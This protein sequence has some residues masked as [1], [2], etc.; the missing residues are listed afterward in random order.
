MIRLLATAWVLSGALGV[1][2]LRSRRATTIALGVVLGPISLVW[3]MLSRRAMTAERAAARVVP[4]TRERSAVA[5]HA[6][7]V[8]RARLRAHAAADAG[9]A[10]RRLLRCVPVALSDA[11]PRRRGA[12]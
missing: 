5:S 2:L 8:P 10:R 12:A 6:R 1:Y 4:A 7:P 3:G 9:G 11:A